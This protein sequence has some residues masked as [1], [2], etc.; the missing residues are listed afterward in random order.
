MY[1]QRD[2]ILNLLLTMQDER[3]RIIVRRFKFEELRIEQIQ[4]LEVFLF[5]QLYSIDCALWICVSTLPVVYYILNIINNGI[6]AS[7]HNGKSFSNY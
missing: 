7:Y 2:W 3:E 6:R 5:F 4:D 1:L